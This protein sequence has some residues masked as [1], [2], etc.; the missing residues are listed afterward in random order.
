VT[1]RRIRWDPPPEETALK[2]PYRD[3][4]LVYGGMSL[5]VVVLGL[6]TGAGVVR[7]LA[8]ACAFFVIATLWSWR[9]LRNRIRKR[10]RSQGERTDP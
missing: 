5:L 3:T 6:V 1:K 2:R 4:A 10:E 9:N 7:T 8:I